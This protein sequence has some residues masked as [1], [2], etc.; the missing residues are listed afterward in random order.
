VYTVVGI[1][2]AVWVA[3]YRGLKVGLD[4]SLVCW[5]AVWILTGATLG[6][7]LSDVLCYRFDEVVEL[8]QRGL[9]WD[10]RSELLQLLTGWRSFGAFFGAI[11]AA[12]MWKRY[13]FQSTV[14]LSLPGLV[15]IEGYWFVRREQRQSILVLGDVALS[16]FPI[17]WI[18]N[19]I[20]V[21]LAHSRLGMRASQESL[22]AAVYQS[23]PR[24][25]LA[26]LDLLAGLLVGA[27]VVLASKR[28]A[29]TGTYVCLVGIAY[30]PMRFA[31]DFLSRRT[32]PRYATLTPN[33]WGFAAL[34]LLSACLLL[35]L[36]TQ[37][38]WSQGFRSGREGG[39][40]K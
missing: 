30:S 39:A 21:V 34:F 3:W 29:R 8:W 7:H 26:M 20:D 18:F 24:Y 4:G 32:T 12:L 19:R 14:W 40:P 9:S 36:F 37:A 15:D 35:W 31:I 16:V 23:V 13:R 27:L 25:N 33:Q 6:G 28:G 38:C 1:A 2:A 17:A 10:N 5:F 11:V 22:V